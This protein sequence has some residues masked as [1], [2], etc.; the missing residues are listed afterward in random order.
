M[1]P[2]PSRDERR[3]AGE[4]A[5]S[6]VPPPAHA[7]WR[8][9]PDRADPVAL[10]EE[11]AATRI[12]ELVPIRYGRM[13]V[14]PFTFYRGAALPM[15]ADLS[16]TPKAGIVVQLCGDAHL[17]NFGLFASPER[18]LVFDIN[19]FD[20]TLHGP[21]EWDVKRL[22]ASIVVAGRTRGFDDH[23]VRHAVHRIR[24]VLPYPDRRV[25]GHGG[26]GGALLQGRRRGNPRL[27]GQAGPAVPP[28]DGEVDPPPRRPPRA[29]EADGGR[30]RGSSPH[31]G[32]SPA[33]HAPAEA[34][35][36]TASR[37]PSPATGTRS[38]RIDGCCST[39]TSSSTP[40][41]RWSGSAASA[42]QRS[43]SCS[44]VAT[45]TTPCSSRSSRPRRRCWSGSC[46]RAPAQPRGARR[47]RPAPPPGRERHPARVGGR[48]E[49][50]PLVRSPVAGPE[51]RRGRRGHDARRPGHVGRA[52]RLGPRPGTCPLRPAGRDRRL[53]RHGQGLRPRHR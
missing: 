9:T 27:R 50:P 10:L 15:A 18:D 51:G 38:P 8:P 6:R 46:R 33:H 40:P 21:F 20:E 19:D 48:G 37:R 30:R 45:R 42:W 31:R 35:P 17:S 13:A 32:P 43:Q 39:G 49:G 52:V 7:G 14:S 22:A 26:D 16:A 29:A 44:W 11:Q 12:P 41:S 28:G 4:A 34:T 2:L 1:S 36:E 5:R 47:R 24:R 3:A 23:G 25:R 53:P